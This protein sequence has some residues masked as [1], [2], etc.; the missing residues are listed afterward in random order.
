MLDSKGNKLDGWSIN[1][2]RGEFEYDPPLGWIGFG[3]KVKGKYED[4][5][6]IDKNNKLNW[7]NAYHGVAKN[8]SSDS[9][10]KIIG[11]IYKSGFKNSHG[12]AYQFYDDIYHKGKKVGNGVYFSRKINV[13]ESYA[14]IININGIKYRTVLMVKLKPSSLRCCKELN[15][16]WI[17]NGTPDDTRPYRILLKKF[18][19]KI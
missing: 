6:W 10:K 17:V 8:Q 4:D 19:D 14:G 11:I 9:I 13:A 12:Q 2:K 1:E 3:L 16:Y 15:D 7:C 18:Y 5:Y